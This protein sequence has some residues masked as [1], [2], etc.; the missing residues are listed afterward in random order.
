MIGVVVEFHSDLPGSRV[1]G[2]LRGDDMLGDLVSL[3]VKDRLFDGRGGEPSIKG[4]WTRRTGVPAFVGETDIPEIRSRPV[5]YGDE[6]IDVVE[7]Y[8]HMC[9]YNEKKNRFL[10]ETCSF[11]GRPYDLLI[12]WVRSGF[13]GAICEEVVL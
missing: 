13:S 6:L 2:D 5:A 12:A 4:G 9:V 8:C 7:P 1:F 11:L 10:I 3:Y